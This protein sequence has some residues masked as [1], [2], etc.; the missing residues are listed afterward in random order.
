[1]EKNFDLIVLQRGQI[2]TDNLRKDG[3]VTQLLKYMD[4]LSK[5]IAAICAASL[6]LMDSGILGNLYITSHPSIPNDF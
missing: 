4:D 5:N 1:M 6:V 2:G 3:R